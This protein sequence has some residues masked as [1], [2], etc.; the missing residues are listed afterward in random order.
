MKIVYNKETKHLV[1][2]MLLFCYPS[3]LNDWSKRI[4]N[5]ARNHL[6]LINQ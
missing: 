2:C 5:K 1:V 6:H 3:F 4:S